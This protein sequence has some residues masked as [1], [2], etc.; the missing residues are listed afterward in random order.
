M[1]A[2]TDK[3]GPVVQDDALL[4]KIE[5]L[6]RE[7][8]ELSVALKPSSSVKSQD[9]TRLPIIGSLPVTT[10]D[11]QIVAP[12]QKDNPQ[13]L[14][15]MSEA[16]MMTTVVLTGI[17]SRPGSE[18]GHPDTISLAEKHLENSFP[19]SSSEDP[20]IA[21]KN[22]VA[23]AG[24][25]NNQDNDNFANET[26]KGRSASQTS[27]LAHTLAEIIKQQIDTAIE[28]RIATSQE[29]GKAQTSDNNENAFA[30]KNVLAPKREAAKSALKNAAKIAQRTKNTTTTSKPAKNTKPIT[31]TSAKNARASKKP[32]RKKTK[33][34]T[35]AA[36]D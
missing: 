27:D 26:T 23:I 4:D 12:S 16:D 10:A 20:F 28:R 13:P 11:K 33:K 17:I 14:S 22:A 2:E 21:I 18:L 36:D 31:K 24:R 9:V 19:S 29:T 8:D 35:G 32:D 3:E 5:T 15:P 6:F 25:S 34:I 7:A 30:P 1:T